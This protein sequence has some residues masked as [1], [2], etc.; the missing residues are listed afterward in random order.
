[1]CLRHED[2]LAV[3]VSPVEYSVGS[4]FEILKMLLHLFLRDFQYFR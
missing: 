1:M 2:V 4:V 3:F